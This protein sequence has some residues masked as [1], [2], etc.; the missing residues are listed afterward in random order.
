MKAQFEQLNTK[1]YH[2]FNAFMFKKEE[3][4]TAFH[5]HP[6]YELTF[7]LSSTGTRYVGN[8]FEDFRE[9]DMVLLGPNLPH[10][11]K[12][13]PGQKS[14]ASAIVIHWNADFIDKKWLESEEFISIKK[15][16]QCASNGIRFSGAAAT[17]F[18][19]K[20]K[21]L[22]KLKSFERLHYFLKLLHGLSLCNDICLLTSQSDTHLL[23]Y[24]NNERIGLTLDY[25]GEHYAQKISL[26][27]IAGKNKMTEEAFS[28]F[29]SKVMR[30]TFFCYLNEYRINH[31]CTQLIE[32]D[33][34][35]SE[36]CY[37]SG[38]DTQ[39]F[40]FRQFKKF[41][42]CTPGSYRANYLK[43]AGW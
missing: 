32:T 15:L 30:K 9:N 6:E 11:W 26:A 21:A 1:P 16:L 7:I 24:N 39:P 36:I 12:N 10:C 8:H 33:K 5:F 2:S 41:K 22:T 35:I 37:E 4:D 40:F 28:R 19:N 38:Y 13:F 29:F 25:I 14:A 20:L 43:T 34:S 27:E 18:R 17:G 3:F 42:N 31:A 23:N